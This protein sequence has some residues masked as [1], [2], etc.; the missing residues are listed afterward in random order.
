MSWSPPVPLSPDFPVGQLVI[1]AQARESVGAWFRGSNRRIHLRARS[2]G[3][4]TGIL[5]AG[6]LG[7]LLRCCTWVAVRQ[8]SEVLVLRSEVLIGWR[9]LQVV[10]RTPFLLGAERLK[11]LFPAVD[12]D[13]VGFQVPTHHCPPEEVLAE[14]LTHGIPVAESHIVYRCTPHPEAL[15]A[16]TRIAPSR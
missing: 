1:L 7:F 9:A 3:R 15:P 14:C 11:Q 4:Y 12:F 2:K 8:A 6:D 5:I 10:T 16:P 13:D